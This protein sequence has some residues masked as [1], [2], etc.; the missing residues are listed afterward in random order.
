MKFVRYA[1]YGLGILLLLYLLLCFLG[2]KKIDAKA[3]LLIPATPEQIFPHIADLKLRESWNPFDDEDTTVRYS[4]GAQTEGVGAEYSWTSKDGPGKIKIDE[5]QA[6]RL[7]RET[8]TFVDFNSVNDV[9]FVLEPVEGGTNVTWTMLGKDGFP[10]LMRGLFGLTMNKGLNEFYLNGLNQLKTVV[11]QA[12]APAAKGRWTAIADKSFP[13]MHYL[14]IRKT[15]TFAEMP[16]FYAEQFPRLMETAQKNGMQPLA[17]PCGLFYVWDEANQ[18]AEMAAA[19]P[20]FSPKSISGFE[21]I[22]LPAQRCFTTDYYG[23]YEGSGSAHL[24]IDEHLAGLG[25]KQKS[26][27]IESYVTDPM[28]VSDPSQVLTQIFYFVE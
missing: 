5:V 28:S 2:D 11:A 7:I 8:L 14:A 17:P 23:P 27:V 10:F 24:A 4:Y 15:V 3:T 6:N 1:L 12:P 20:V 9:S 18:R 16:A 25:L 26:P 21:V 19:V 22:T 13:T